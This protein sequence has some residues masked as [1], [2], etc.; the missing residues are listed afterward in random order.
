M[1]KVGASRKGELMVRYAYAAAAL[2]V[3][4]LLA[5][6]GVE[7]YVPLHETGEA[8]SIDP[9]SGHLIRTTSWK[10]SDGGFAVT[11][12]DITANGIE[13]RRAPPPTRGVIDLF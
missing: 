6:C 9:V 11:T 13:V 1:A 7:Y 3:V 10:N 12:D 4:L 8:F 5:G 2:G